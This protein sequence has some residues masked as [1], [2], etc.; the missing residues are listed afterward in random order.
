MGAMN[1]I[2]AVGLLPGLL[3]G[4]S[5]IEAQEI[6]GQVK[7]R[8]NCGDVWIQDFTPVMGVHTGPGLVGASY[9][10]YKAYD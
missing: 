9:S 4:V 5:D 1:A 8:L 7:S 6:A 2:Y 3:V 10:T